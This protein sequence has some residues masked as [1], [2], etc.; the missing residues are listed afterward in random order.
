M[1]LLIKMA[2][3]ND[4]TVSICGQAPSK[5]PEFTEFPVRNGIDSISVN[6]DKAMETIRLVARVEKKIIME[7]LSDLLKKE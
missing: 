4:C 7:R 6:P 5:Y 3:E 1:S 2:H